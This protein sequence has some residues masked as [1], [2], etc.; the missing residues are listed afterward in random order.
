[1]GIGAG[2]APRGQRLKPIGNKSIILI[3]VAMAVPKDENWLEWAELEEAERN[4][5]AA[6]ELA[7]LKEQMISGR[8]FVTDLLTQLSPTEQ[9]NYRAT[10]EELES[11]F[12]S[13]DARLGLS[14]QSGYLGALEKLKSRLSQAPVFLPYVTLVLKQSQG[15]VNDSDGLVKILDNLRRRLESYGQLNEKTEMLEKWNNWRGEIME[16][17]G[18]EANPPEDMRQEIRYRIAAGGMGLE[19]L[20][21]KPQS[22]PDNQKRRVLEL[23]LRKVDRF[24]AYLAEHPGAVGLID[25]GYDFVEEERVRK[26]L[27]SMKV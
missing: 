21:T 14:A 18:R 2:N 6:P 7:A 17:L 8:R 16:V 25:A 11:V 15:L 13:M 24:I 4:R 27:E 22:T 12:R 1:M 5:E 10:V 20:R 9:G 23:Y 3:L 19:P 26:V